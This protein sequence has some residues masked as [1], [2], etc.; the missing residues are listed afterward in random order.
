MEK[1]HRVQVLDEALEA[2]VKLA[3]RY[4]PDRQLP[5]KSVTLLDTACARVS[6]SHHATPA[7]VEDSSGA[8]K[9]CD[10]ELEI[11]GREQ[12][13]GID[14]GEREASARKLLARRRTRCDT[15]KPRG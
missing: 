8:S 12:A 11:I 5:D 6:V 14:T 13:I 2:A 9:R 4:M 1:H 10:T 7:A 3:H 15:L